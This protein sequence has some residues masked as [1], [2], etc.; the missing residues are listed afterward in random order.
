MEPGRLILLAAPRN[1]KAREGSD[2]AV[3]ASRR[4]ASSPQQNDTGRHGSASCAQRV[5]R[6]TTCGQEL[7]DVV[8]SAS[9]A[10]RRAW[11][12]ICVDG[13]H[14]YFIPPPPTA[15]RASPRDVDAN[16]AGRRS[17]DL[18]HPGA[19]GNDNTSIRPNERNL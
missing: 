9:E 18:G 8:V 19:P 17:G 12:L 15:V 16:P 5:C 13:G 2:G 6:D 1:D 10:W 7:L 11:D 3:F 4:V 14:R